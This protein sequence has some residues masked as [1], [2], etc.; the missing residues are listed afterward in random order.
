[1]GGHTGYVIN[2]LH[3]VSQTVALWDVIGQNQVLGVV[4]DRAAVTL[5]ADWYLG[6]GCI[7]QTI[8]NH[9]CHR[10]PMADINDLD[11]VYFDAGDLSEE[12][13][14]A[15]LRRVCKDLDIPVHIDV[16]NQARVHLWYEKHFGYPIRPY[17]SLEDA[18]DSWPTTATSI[19]VRRWQGESV[20]YA[21]YGLDDLFAMIICPNKKQITRELYEAKVRRWR[22]CWPSLRIIP[23]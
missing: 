21:P 16:K 18:I 22:A 19:G 8:W 2:G 4:L 14:D 5:P 6:A 23:W 3:G 12:A 17:T 13:E 7:A 20:I 1:M 11:L 10:E 15:C 9:L